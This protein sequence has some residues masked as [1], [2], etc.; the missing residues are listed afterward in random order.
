MI[1]KQLVDEDVVNY[2]KTS[3][4]IAFPHCSFKCG[5]ACQ[6]KHLKDA[7]DIDIPVE[8]IVKRYLKNPFSSAVVMQGL[9]PLDSMPDLWEF[10]EKFR[11]ACNDDIVIYTGYSYTDEK[12]MQLIG[13]I[14]GHRYTNIIIKVGGYVENRPS[15]Y[16]PELGV[17]LASDNQG[18][19][20]F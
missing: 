17:E 11:D 3:M 4:V 12:V 2:K 15:K 8:A 14:D 1:I 16:S 7:P 9:E 13:F 18:V 6:N 19:V 20:V 5:S 10:M